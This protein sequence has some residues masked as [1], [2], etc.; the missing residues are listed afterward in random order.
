MKKTF[1][2]IYKALGCDDMRP[3]MQ[4]AIVE[5]GKL[6]ATNGKILIVSDFAI[7]AEHSELAEGK[8]FDKNLLRWM[9]K[10]DFK[11]LECTATGITGCLTATPVIPVNCCG[12]PKKSRQ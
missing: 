1:P 9:A 10:K 7:F 11:R 5:N 6:I 8:V 12:M 3:A 2:N 4:Y